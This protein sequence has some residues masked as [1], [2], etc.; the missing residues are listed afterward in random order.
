MTTSAHFRLSV[1][2]ELF[3]RQS[4]PTRA[5]S[6]WAAVSAECACVCHMMLLISFSPQ[7]TG[8]CARVSSSW[9]AASKLRVRA[10]VRVR[11]LSW[12][13]TCVCARACTELVR[14]VWGSDASAAAIREAEHIRAHND[15]HAP[16]PQ[17]R[18]AAVRYLC[19]DILDSRLPEEHFHVV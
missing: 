5:F 2:T 14:S 19:D 12:C 11:V 17:P 15:L 6:M 1:L 18:A 16:Q 3:R 13:A 7:A 8:T 4:W 10:C 9:A